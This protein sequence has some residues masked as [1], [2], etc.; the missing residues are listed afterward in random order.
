MMRQGKSTGIDA[1]DCFTNDLV[2]RKTNKWRTLKERLAPTGGIEATTTLT[3]TQH[4]RNASALT[5]HAGQM[6][7][8]CA[9][10]ETMMTIS[11]LPAQYTLAAAAKRILLDLQGIRH[12]SD[13]RQCVD[14]QTLSAP[15]IDQ[16]L[17]STLLSD[18]V[19]SQPHR[20]G[21]DFYAM[22]SECVRWRKLPSETVL[23]D[24][25]QY[26]T[27][28][29]AHLTYAEQLMRLA[30]EENATMFAAHAGF[31]HYRARA[32]WHR[33][34]HADALREWREA[35]AT[36]RTGQLVQMAGALR[37]FLRETVQLT[38]GEDCDETVAELVLQTAQYLSARYGENEMLM[39]VWQC[40]FV[41]E[42]F[43]RQQRAVRM[44][45]ECEEIRSFVGQK[46]VDLWDVWY[47]LKKKKF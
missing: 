15:H 35:Y 25:L 32:R 9:G 2:V 12:A 23:I 11:S 37:R 3:T 20:P 5:G 46:Y 27:R 4:Q 40:C 21:R 10:V 39:S 24:C 22:L 38:F 33:G 1:I 45:N 43:E 19:L 31:V 30:A 18:A 42:W 8:A 17:L 41:S 7:S 36:M 16:L 47:G 34:E 26:L 44:F 6:Q 13:I 29:A 28:Y 14:V